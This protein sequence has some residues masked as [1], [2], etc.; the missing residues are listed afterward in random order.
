MG[1]INHDQVKQL[2]NFEIV[3]SPLS[4]E[5]LQP[6]EVLPSILTSLNL[7]KPKKSLNLTWKDLEVKV[8][9]KKDF[10]CFN[11]KKE[12]IIEG[13]LETGEIV[14]NEKRTVIINKGI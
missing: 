1:S 12:L 6:L 4:L 14:I 9:N 7:G 5:A 3:M 13:S 8:P 10:F 2:K 11:R